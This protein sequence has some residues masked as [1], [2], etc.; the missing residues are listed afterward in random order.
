MKQAVRSYLASI[1]P[2][3]VKKLKDINAY[4]YVHL[5]ILGLYGFTAMLPGKT[6]NDWIFTFIFLLIPMFFMGWSDMT[7]RCQSQCFY[8]L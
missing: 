6:V 8:V 5:F 1:H 4:G 7:S 2:R 3:N